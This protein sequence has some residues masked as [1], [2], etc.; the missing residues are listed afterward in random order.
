MPP[1]LD[2]GV[3]PPFGCF[4]HVVRPAELTRSHGASERIAA[5]EMTRRRARERRVTVGV[6]KNYD[7]KDCIAELAVDGELS[8]DL[9]RRTAIFRLSSVISAQPG[10]Y[11]PLSTA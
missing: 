2:P 5:V 7:S 11:A 8:Y 4:G 10:W 9:A 1:R 3:T 6:D